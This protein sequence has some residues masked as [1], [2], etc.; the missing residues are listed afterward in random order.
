MA[1]SAARFRAAPS[2]SRSAARFRASRPAV[3]A[4][5]VLLVLA[6]VTICAPLISAAVGHSPNQLFP[7][8]LSARLGL[9]TGPGSHFLFGIDSVGRDVFPALPVILF[10]S[11]AS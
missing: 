4:L 2:R 10:A 8:K 3:A 6:A 1:A 7:D 5:V 9:P 11:A